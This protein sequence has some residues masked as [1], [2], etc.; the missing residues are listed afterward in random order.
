[1]F[2]E[3]DEMVE[4]ETVADCERS[5]GWETLTKQQCMHNDIETY[6]STKVRPTVQRR[7]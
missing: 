1:M 7:K 2:V 4:V 6:T 3:E 5:A